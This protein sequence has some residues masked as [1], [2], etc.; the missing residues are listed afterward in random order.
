MRK[1][2]APKGGRVHW[3]LYH[4][5][6]DFLKAYELYYN[7]S[8]HNYV[9]VRYLKRRIYDI[10]IVFQTSKHYWQC[11]YANVV[12]RKYEHFGD[13]TTRRIAKRMWYLWKFDKIYWK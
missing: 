8:E 3:L 10:F 5:D 9:F 2:G 13:N 6:I 7:Y 11:T 1:V 4:L 12:K